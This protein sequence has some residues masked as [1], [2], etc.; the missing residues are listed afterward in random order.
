[1]ALWTASNNLLLRQIEEG[2]TLREPTEGESRAAN[3]QPI[4]LDVVSG[5]ALKIIG[6]T[7]PPGLRIV[8]QKI[9][10]TPFEVARETEF[11]FVV[12]ASKDSEIDDRTFRINVV[13]ADLPVWGTSA[14]S[15]PIGK[16]NTYYILDNSPIDFQLIATDS[17]IAAGQT[18]EYFVASGDGELPP[19]IQLTRDGRIVGV[20]DPVLAIDTLANSGYYDSNSYG[21]Y[22]FDF[23]V[24]SANG[25]DSF[26][27]DIKFYDKSIATKSPK[28]LNRNYQFRVS[29]SDG[30]TIEK[31]LFRIFVVG[32]DFLRADNTIMQSGNT[33]FGADASH[34]R[35][36]IWLTPADLGYRRAD[37][38]VTLYMDII[39]ASDIVGFV[40]YTLED[41]NDDGSESIIPPGIELDSGSGEL[42]GVVPYQ[43]SVTKE[44]KFTV[45]ATRYVGPATNT[46]QINFTT[47]EET[48]AQTR[49]PAV[50]IIRNNL[51]EI[52]TVENTDFTSIGAPN[53]NIGT[54]FRASGATSGKGTVKQAS[55]PYKLKINKKSNIEVLLDQTFNIKGTIFKITAI[56]NKNP[57]YDVLTLSK[58]LD[59]YLK[60]D[61][62]FT[63]TIVTATVDTN[64]AFKNKTF[65]VKL[66]GKIDSRI[67]W[68]S[69]KALGTINANLTSTLNVR[70]TTSVPNAVVR[71]SKISGRL[72]NGLR[73]SIDGEIS[74]KVQQFGE[75]VYKS[76]WKP[77]RN[78]VANDIV[79]V[80]TTLYKCLIAHTSDADFVTDTAKWEVY[81]AFAV[82]GLT[83]FD[84]ND[85]IL[86]SGTTSIDKT[87]TF[88]VQAEDQFGF[89]ATTKSFT[90]AINDPNELTFSN[91][92]IKPFLGA[93]QQF[94]YNSFI[95]DPIVF[96]PSSIYRPNDT[97][98]GLQ[99]DLRMLMYAGI[100]N[101]E[102]NKFVGAAAKNHRKKQFQ[103][104]EVKT[105]V[106]YA[107]GTRDAVYEVV[108]VD[109]IDPLDSN[110]GTVKQSINV[111]TNNK[112]LI[113]NGSYE[114]NDNTSTTINQEPD[115]FR[116]ITN[117]LKIDSDAISID[118]STQTKK[119]IS[120]I[121]NMRDRIAQV[122]VT[123]NNF[124]PLWM[125]TPQLNNIEELGYIPC[126]VLAYCKP[127]TSRDIFLNIK[128]NNFIFNSIN[129][130]IDR[131]IIDST[132]GKSNEQYIVFANYDFNI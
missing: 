55:G 81:E 113:N 60:K 66:L 25:Y 94:I 47:Y 50:K 71:Y 10:G 41:F 104:G 115:R 95:S 44:Y 19:G 83:T 38:Y 117:T 63:K 61:E 109:I 129:F 12:R 93:S 15:L 96:T 111:K 21:E 27:Y 34:I 37:N 13:G 6:G 98:F 107:P 45:R 22:P 77:A 31:R 62:T 99:K 127:G 8:D 110:S 9:Q 33:L 1:M 64:S 42:A 122:G 28:K 119:Y 16:N 17:D 84:G 128:N 32:D 131:Y 46:A 65:T 103:F 43:P 14:G 59:A 89:S 75:N 54:Q 40:N 101:V 125:R 73:I 76:F 57:L 5:S 53:N 39:D 121:T 102:M 106:A 85:N 78:Y 87:Y 24:R 35:T 69:V 26:F 123:D 108:Y 56:N 86:D 3:L 105:A 90:I 118:E 4:D 114:E 67:V 29:V 70:A 79:K 68:Q 52:L 74:G 18:L 97:E 30:D 23:G 112:R 132:K 91:I 20:V 82:S 48:F 51:Y 126:V 116:P 49:T 36:P 124:L 58:P 80:N 120:N 72:P 11:K 130:E 92:Y 7:L 88:T 100:E 2:K